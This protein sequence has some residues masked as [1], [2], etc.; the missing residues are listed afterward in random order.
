MPWQVSYAGLITCWFLGHKHVSF[1]FL[2]KL[3]FMQS[4][5]ASSCWLFRNTG[6]P[7]PDASLASAQRRL[8]N[9]PKRP[10]KT[11]TWTVGPMGGVVQ[12]KRWL[13]FLRG[14]FNPHDFSVYGKILHREKQSVKKQQD[15]N[16]KQHAVVLLSHYLVFVPLKPCMKGREPPPPKKNKKLWKTTCSISVWFAEDAKLD[17]EQCCSTSGITSTGAETFIIHKL[18][19]WIM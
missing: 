17:T 3:R 7:W 14:K 2:I 11:L 8:M 19:A 12:I 4:L 6:F 18:R 9:G 5:A 16:E 13:S 1:C 10:D 15:I